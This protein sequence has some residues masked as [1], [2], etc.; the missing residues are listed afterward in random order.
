MRLG[1]FEKQYAPRSPV[2]GATLEILVRPSADEFETWSISMGEDV[3]DHTHRIS[4]MGGDS[5][6]D[7][8]SVRGILH[9]DLEWL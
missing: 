5:N 4:R 1:C 2:N 3:V 9:R 7:S 6:S 8:R